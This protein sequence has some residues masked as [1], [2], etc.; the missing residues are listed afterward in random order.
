MEIINNII[1]AILAGAVASSKET[2]GQAV[3]EAYSSLKKII[4]SRITGIEFHAIENNSEKK[5][6]TE[7]EI[8]KHLCESKKSDLDVIH[9]EAIK[10]LRE[11]IL[12]DK[13]TATS[14]DIQ[15]EDMQIGGNFKWNSEKN[16]ADNTNFTA[17]KMKVEKDFTIGE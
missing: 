3:K 13:K 9:G 7:E 15:L 8:K 10:M 1:S 16:K 17:R 5:G 6:T 2:A 12:N 14:L 11:I 4:T